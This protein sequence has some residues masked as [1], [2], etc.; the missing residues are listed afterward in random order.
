MFRRNLFNFYKRKQKCYRKL[1]F[2]IYSTVNIINKKKP[3]K[4]LRHSFDVQLYSCLLI[5][6]EIK[7]FT[8]INRTS[9]H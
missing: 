9:I 6:D 8:D 2:S 7:L 5:Q 1:I 4:H 3:D